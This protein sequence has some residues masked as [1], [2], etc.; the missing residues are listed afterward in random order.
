MNNNVFTFSF[1]QARTIKRGLFF[2]TSENPQEVKNHFIYV[3]LKDLP[4][5]FPLGPNPRRPDI[6]SKP[7][8]QMKETLEIEP[9]YFT[10]CNRGLYLTAEKIDFSEEREG[11]FDRK[12]TIDFGSSDE[13]DPVGGLVDG[14]HTYA[15]LLQHKNNPEL[16][17][18]P[19]FVNIVEGA[20]DFA[21]KLARARNTSIQVDEKSIANLEKKFEPIKEALGDYS[22]KVIYYSNQGILD[23]SSVPVEDI[24]AMMTAINRELYDRDNQPTIAYTG[25]AACLTKW[26]NPKHQASYEKLY[27]VLHSIIEVY[28]HLYLNFKKYAREGGIIRFGG[29][30][31]VD[32]EVRTTLPFS[33]VQVEYN[34]AKPF[35][36]PIFASLRFL[37][38]KDPAENW[39]WGVDPR[40]FLDKH[41]PTLVKKLI[42]A[43]SKDYGSNPNKTGKSRI[44]WESLAS[45]VENY[46]LTEKLNRIS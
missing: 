28:E 45:N 5:D 21:T 18:M 46:Y 14:G 40:D 30:S 13:G 29:L 24:V 23:D 6:S 36:M 33:G 20:L 42:D 43:H 44:L 9:Q 27:P 39:K 16:A 35:I 34:L 12:V 22:K 41:G 19:I 31:G 10:D 2:N 8:R 26:L 37:L 1:L 32:K 4:E 3:A 7:C 11:G 38:E 17:N 15:I 25:S